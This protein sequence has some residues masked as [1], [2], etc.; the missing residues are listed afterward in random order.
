MFFLP[1]RMVLALIYRLYRK[2]CSSMLNRSIWS[3]S[4]LLATN[5][6]ESIERGGTLAKGPKPRNKLSNDPELQNIVL[7]QSTHRECYAPFL[8][9][10][11]LCKWA[12]LCRR[13]Y[14]KRIFIPYLIC[15]AHCN[16][17][18][19]ATF[20]HSNTRNWSWRDLMIGFRVW[21]SLE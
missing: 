15:T 1:W 2:Q 18:L 14:Q 11:H 17:G 13:Q 4:H 9:V 7:N 6:V 12:K 5:L 21:H 8:L 10:V 16:Q 20:S 19:W 3:T